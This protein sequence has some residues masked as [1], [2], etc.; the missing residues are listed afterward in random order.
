MEKCKARL[1]NVKQEEE[2]MD[3]L[4][5]GI[6]DAPVSSLAYGHMVYFIYVMPRFYMIGHFKHLGK[7][8]WV[9]RKRIKEERWTDRTS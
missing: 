2:E 4:K 3:K 8:Y 6:I 1:H 5:I 7:L 9:R